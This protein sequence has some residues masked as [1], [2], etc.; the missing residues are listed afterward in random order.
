MTIFK[1]KPTKD[2]RC[3]YFRKSKNNKQYTSKK[4]YSKKEC[5]DALS[6]F[7]LKNENPINK[8]FDLVAD[9][10]FE[11]LNRKPSTINSYLKAY[12]V[13]IKPYFNKSYINHINVQ[14]I[15]KWEKYMLKKR[16]L[17]SD[18]ITELDNTKLSVSYLN[19]CYHILKN[20]FD[21]GIKN[22]SLQ[23]NPVSMYGHFE[24]DNSKIKNDNKK[25]ITFDEFKNF[26]SVID[27]P[28]WNTYFNFLFY[29][30]TRKGEAMALHW[31][32]IDF[33]NNKIL[34][35]ATLQVDIKGKIFETTTKTNKDRI[36]LMNEQLK[37]ILYNYKQKQMEYLNFSENWYV[38]GGPIP[39]SKTTADRMKHKYF[40]LSGVK[41]ITNHQFRHSLTTILIQEYVKQQQ[42]NNVKIDK[43]SFLSA[44]AN[45]NGHTV[46]V[47]MKHYAY[48][49]PDT[50][51]SQV[52]ELLNNLEKNKN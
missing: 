4:Y 48:L 10:Y 32:N 7:I 22:Y 31:N 42:Q 21:Y 18:G 12:R 45:R 11:N 8:R 40:E 19:K 2:G 6:A 47:M 28:L 14:D 25:I 1:G 26:I 3:Y 51:Q 30:D 41:E 5:E 20:I 43:Y 50:E 15:S 35:K 29:A 13:H 16:K 52:I 39:I 36:I 24:S 34:I 46:E 33:D 44:L 9:E 37:N 23:Y 27:E 17:S 49:F 38:F